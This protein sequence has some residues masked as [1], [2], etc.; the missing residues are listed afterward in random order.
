MSYG[1]LHIRENSTME[2]NQDTA[3]KRWWSENPFTYKRD[4]GVGIQDETD[5]KF[6]VKCESKLRRH[7]PTYQM[8]NAPLLSNFFSYEDIK[9]KKIL[10]IAVG[11]G[12][13]LVEFSRQ[14]CISTGID[15]SPT[16]VDMTK[17]NLR[18]RK[19][20][21]EVY[22]MD[23]QEMTFES[24]TFDFVCAQGC[25]MHMPNTQKA[26]DEIYRVLKPGSKVHAWVYNK[27]F[28]Y[29]F[30]ILLIR[31]FFQGYIFK[32]KFDL[33]RLTSRFSDGASIGGNPHTKF[34]NASEAR[35][36]FTKAGFNNVKASI[37][38]NPEEFHAFPTKRYSFGKFLGPKIKKFIGKFSGLGLV[39]SAEK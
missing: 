12:V 16:A 14:G 18:L 11:T 36:Y 25:L 30:N 34:H 39:I 23:A 24:N 15:I 8:P 27:G 9:N 33:T 38:Y 22:E 29:W 3:V 35:Q 7:G 10:D 2:S 21:A 13:T 20:K 26:V 1:C 17:K 19:L 4:V 31:G 37:V 32:F 28:Y 6:F 5:L